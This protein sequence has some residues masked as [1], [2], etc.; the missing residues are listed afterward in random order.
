MIRRIFWVVLSLAV[1]FLI[2]D[3]FGLFDLSK[4]RFT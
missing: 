4:G 3:L 2:L 1:L